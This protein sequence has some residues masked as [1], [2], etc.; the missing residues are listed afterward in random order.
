MLYLIIRTSAVLIIPEISELLVTAISNCTS[1]VTAHNQ[2]AMF[3]TES[4]N[5]NQS[6]TAKR[7]L[8]ALLETSGLVCGSL[9]DT[10]QDRLADNENMLNSLTIENIKT[11]LEKPR[12]QILNLT[13]EACLKSRG[14]PFSPDEKNQA[15]ATGMRGSFMDSSTSELDGTGAGE[16]K[17]PTIDLDDEILPSETPP[18][19]K[20]RFAP[21]LK[22][23]KRNEKDAAEAAS[24][25]AA[26]GSDS[27]VIGLCLS[28][29]H[30]TLGH[31]DTVTRQTAFD[32]NEL[33]DR[34]YKYVSSTDERGW[35]AGG[36]ERGDPYLSG[37][38]REFDQAGS[39]VSSTSEDSAGMK[40]RAFG[41]GHKIASPDSVHIPIIKINVTSAAVI[42]EIISALA[43]G[44]IFIPEV[45]VLPESLSVNATSPPDLQVAFGCEKNDDTSPEDWSNWCLE[46]LHNQLY[47]YFS[48][49]GAQ[50]SKRPFQIT[51]ASKVRWMT[52]KHMNRYFARSEQVIHSWRE[53]GPQYLQPPYSDDSSR[54]VILE[55]ITRPHGIYLIQNGVP[56]NYFA[57][58]FKPPYATKVRRSLIKNV[59]NKSWDSKHRDWM[60]YSVPRRRGPVQVMSS[61]LGCAN[62][63]EVSPVHQTA[64]ASNVDLFQ[65]RSDFD[66]VHEKKDLGASTTPT[67]EQGEIQQRTS[68]QSDTQQQD[69]ANAQQPDENERG[70]NMKLKSSIPSDESYELSGESTTDNV[71]DNIAA[72]SSSRRVE[73]KSRA[74]LSSDKESSH[75]AERKQFFSSDR[76]GRTSSFGSSKG[77]SFSE[78][79]LADNEQREKILDCELQQQ[80]ITCNQKVDVFE[81]VMM[82]HQK[83]HES[84]ADK[85]ARTKVCVF[86]IPSNLGFYLSA[87]LHL[88]SGLVVEHLPFILLSCFASQREGK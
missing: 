28:R 39:T 79:S 50:W 37:A 32:F 72:N 81:P 10:V 27:V 49:I 43:R 25:Q 30:P 73:Q 8:S 68:D 47:D 7:V 19:H 87:T 38:A 75:D 40:A 52:A 12:E 64:A 66:L 31:P 69:I 18:K 33:Q 70:I 61:V 85:L 74:V 42:D 59:I 86:H 35:R 16:G 41:A 11:K 5:G 88:F 4:G 60:S 34:D 14:E 20:S 45:S 36:G 83:V 54:G 46:F 29:K 6:G 84:R 44:E 26:S 77:V 9:K 51:L 56:T 17:A 3:N 53:K 21:V 24:T 71:H 22:E 23:A 2:T 67:K 13:E 62:P 58:N 65:M 48:P 78:S 80:V 57:P 76:Q 15:C 63:G 1:A 82:P 55:E